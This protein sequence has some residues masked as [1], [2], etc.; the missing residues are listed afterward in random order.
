MRFKNIKDGNIIGSYV[1]LMNDFCYRHPCEGCMIEKKSHGFCIK[2][3]KDH[4]YE[5][6]A[7]MGYEVV[8][9]H[10]P[11]HEKTHADAIENARVHLEEANMDK[12]LKDWTLGEAKEYC[13][14]R[15]GN[16]A[17]DCIFSK[18]GIGMVCGIATKPVWWTLP[19]KPR[20]TQQE[21]ERAKN[22][23]EVVGP[24]ELRKVADMVT[25]KAD[26]K[27]IY[28]RKDAFPSLKNEVAVTLDEIIGGASDA[29][30]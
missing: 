13:T 6:A 5:A 28:L 11:T 27:I 15:N 9:K 4:P 25:M 21:V 26:G 14:S 30:T 7:L 2:W 29:Q 22:L 10:T 18:K 12:P 20:F 17:D 1:Q 3:I 23:L 16:C 19:E 8:D 24:A